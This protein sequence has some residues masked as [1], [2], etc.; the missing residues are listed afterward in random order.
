MFLPWLLVVTSHVLLHPFSVFLGDQ[1][2]REISAV[3]WYHQIRCTYRSPGKRMLLQTIRF[4][5]YTTRDNKWKQPEKKN[6]LFSKLKNLGCS[7]KISGGK[8][9]FTYLLPTNPCFF[10][11]MTSKRLWNKCH[12]QD[13]LLLSID[14]NN[15]IRIVVFTK[16]L[17]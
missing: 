9:P 7:R 6:I 3:L 1:A 14:Y 15:N 11:S 10:G 8:Q 16:R 17:L 13:L 2:S 12:Y 5:S 4:L